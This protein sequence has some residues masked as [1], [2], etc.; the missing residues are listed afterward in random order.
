VDRNASMDL[1]GLSEDEVPR[2][3]VLEGTWWRA[4]ALERRLPAL[5]DVREL[6]MPDLW[7]GWVG[8]VPVV[9]ACVYGASRVVEPVHLL[10]LCGTPVVAHLGPCFA[11]SPKLSVGDIVLPEAAAIGEGVSQYYRRAGSSPGTAPANLGKVARA[12]ALLAPRGVYPHR[13]TTFTT[14]ALLA[15]PKKL[16]ATWEKAG[17]LAVDTEAS[18]V[19]SAA[20]AFRM[21]A[22]SLLHVWDRLP[23][24]P[25]SEPFT[26]DEEAAQERARDEVWEIA[27]Q[28]A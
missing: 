20:A 24:R 26:D 4:E 21:R 12:A 14:E 1:L 5:D 9:Y 28:L 15:M 11:L 2:L 6:G 25:Y 8:D 3:L 19:F 16:I 27:L 13:G 23:R 7:H 22:V 18:A 10:G 17:H